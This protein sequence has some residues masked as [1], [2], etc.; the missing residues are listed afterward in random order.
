MA[1]VAPDSLDPAVAVERLLER[2]DPETAT[3]ELVEWLSERATRPLNVNTAS[4]ADLA[5]LPGLGMLAAVRIVSVRASEGPFSTLDAVQRA[6]SVD[7]QTFALLRPFLTVSEKPASASS[8][9]GRFLGQLEGRLIQRMTRRLDVG[10]GYG[11]DTTRTTY[12]GSPE[13]WYTRLQLRDARHLQLNLTLEK[14][15]GEA[16]RWRPATRTYGF[17]HVSAHAVLRNVGPVE[18]LVLGDYTVSFGQGVGLWDSFSFSKGRD[19]IGPAARQAP[20]ISPFGSTEE[21]R[22]FRGVAAT[23]RVHRRV[24]ASAFVSRRSLDATTTLAESGAR[25]PAR[26][27]ESG[28]H[29]TPTELAN[30]DM[31]DETVVGGAVQWHNGAS[32][33]GL[34]GYHSLV[35][36]SLIAPPETFRRFDPTGRRH[37]TMSAFGGMAWGD[38]YAFGEWVRSPDSWGGIGGLQID[39]TIAEAVVSVRH[40]PAAF[41]S[42]HGRAFGERGDP[43]SNESGAY[44]AAR[45]RP[46]ADWQISAY[47]D[48]YRFPWLR[49]ATP[50]PASGLDTRLVIEHTPRPWLTYYLQA[51]HEAQ[52]EGVTVGSS[53]IMRAVRPATRQSLR[54]HGEYA[55]SDHLTFRMR[56]EG[57]QSRSAS[58][59]AIGTLLYHGVRWR[60]APWLRLDTRWAL[61]D[62]EDYAARIYAYEHD[63]LYAFSIPVF[64][65]QGARHY[66]LAHIAPSNHLRIE[67]KYAATR[68]RNVASVGSGLDEVT[69]S[70]LR[71]L[72]AQVR[73]HF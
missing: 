45:I 54:L 43:P 50:R 71:D 51:R 25:V 73:W 48:Q 1:Q 37:Y 65:G 3:D 53:P 29:R 39:K 6:A 27:T 52:E 47:V 23:A 14:D 18:T 38:L 12:V 9:R 67:L 36:P 72:R 17:D 66:L 63:L 41:T 55:F 61:F 42:L 44:I 24:L 13:R 68:Y 15:P 62:T 64:N 11:R 2:T 32:N 56:V 35:D 59:R 28:L 70:R 5:R 8:T 16:F 30:K 26:R 10:R 34:A 33:L 46:A 20:G 40:F 49:F 57:I 22:F 4:A 58:G 21:N 69:G 31:L 19:V 60:P 7:G